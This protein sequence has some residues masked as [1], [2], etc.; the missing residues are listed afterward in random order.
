MN[1]NWRSRLQSQK[2]NFNPFL[3]SN[4]LTTSSESA[5]NARPSRKTFG[6]IQI[7]TWKVVNL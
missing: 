2:S 7:F 4:K 5:K 1:L 6:K 3:L